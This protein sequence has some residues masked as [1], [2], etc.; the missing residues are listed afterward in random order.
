MGERTEQPSSCQ[1]RL[2][3]RPAGTDPEPQ[4]PATVHVHPAPKPSASIHSLPICLYRP[5]T[6]PPLLYSFFTANLSCPTPRAP[7]PSIHTHRTTGHPH[8]GPPATAPASAPSQLGSPPGLHRLEGRGAG[9][10]GASAAQPRPFTHGRG[11]AQTQPPALDV[12][13]VSPTQARLNGF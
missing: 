13:P 3:V 8:Q 4:P 5:A 11:V 12:S 9:T 7:T 1:L 6:T 10:T 2:A